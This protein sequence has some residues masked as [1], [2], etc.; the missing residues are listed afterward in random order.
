MSGADLAAVVVTIAAVAACTVLVISAWALLR[1]LRQAGNALE[2]VANEAPVALADLRRAAVQADEELGRVDGLLDRADRV[3]G[4]LEDASKLA[5]LAVTNPVI[6]AA[7]LASGVRQGARRLR[8]G[9]DGGGSVGGM[10]D[11][12]DGAAPVGPMR[13]APVGPAG[14]PAGA[15]P[16]PDGRAGRRRSQRREA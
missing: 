8:S 13:T 1:T 3:S 9:A 2:R 4:T 10:A 14:A 7:A 11:A 16:A 15:G 12:A 6:K 5:Y